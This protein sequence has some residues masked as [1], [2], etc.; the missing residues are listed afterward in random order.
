VGTR[1]YQGWGRNLKIHGTK[2][3]RL[4]V[5]LSTGVSRTENFRD[6]RVL[7]EG[8]ENHEGYLD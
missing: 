5:L 7:N 1:P 3:P 8:Y 6:P 2:W 4:R